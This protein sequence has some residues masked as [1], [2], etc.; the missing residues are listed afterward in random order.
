V[1]WDE[2]DRVAKKVKSCVKLVGM[3]ASFRLCVW[4][5][6]WAKA[7]TERGEAV[8]SRLGE[9]GF[10]VICLTEGAVGGNRRS[11]CGSPR[12]KPGGIQ[13]SFGLLPEGGYWIDS[14]PDYG[15]RIIEGRRKVLLWS[16]RPWREVDRV[17]D[18]G[19]PGGRFVSGLTET[20]VGDVR[21]VGVCIPW[22]WA[23]VKTGRKDRERWEDHLRYLEGLERYLRGL[24]GE[25]RGGG[26]ELSDTAGE[27]AP[28]ALTQGPGEARHSWDAALAQA[29][30]ETRRRAVGE[31]RK[32][33][34]GEQIAAGTGTAR[35][36][37]VVL[38]GDFN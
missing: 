29:R 24:D 26:W 19:M 31:S 38:V 30:G 15:Y 9:A 25:Q 3:G 11:D 1:V 28:L 7:G 22:D 17:G 12:L 2:G 37:P 36:I 35:G 27:A 20:P 33:G 23:H 4:N 8:R 34:Q 14:D 32:S 21:V 5:V 18:S 16:R 6:M 10:D 13:G